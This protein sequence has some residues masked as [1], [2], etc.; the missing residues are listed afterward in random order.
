MSLAPLLA[1]DIKIQ[2]HAFAA[3]AAFGLG[4]V[5]FAGQKGTL[6]HRTLGWSWTALMLVVCVSAFFI[7]NVRPGSWSP[8]HGLALFV[9]V[10]LPYAIYLAHRRNVQGHARAMI[11]LFFSAL[12][13]AGA[14]TFLPGRIMHAV[15]FGN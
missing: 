11:A 5:Q 8:I 7:H 2:I 13:L 14:F 12:F 4:L 3:M 6:V 1:A 15:A 10:M 9:L